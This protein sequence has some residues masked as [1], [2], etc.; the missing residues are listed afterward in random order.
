[1]IEAFHSADR[2]YNRLR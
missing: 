1:M 2:S